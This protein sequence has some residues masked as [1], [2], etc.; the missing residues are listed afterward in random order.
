MKLAAELGG[1]KKRV[2]MPVRD[3]ERENSIL[4]RMREE[5]YGPLDEAAVLKIFQLIICESRRIEESAS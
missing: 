3:Q 2:G 4:R 1:I 5:N